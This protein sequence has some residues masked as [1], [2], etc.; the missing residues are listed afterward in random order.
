MAKQIS[1]GSLVTGL[2]LG[3]IIGIYINLLLPTSYYLFPN[4]NYVIIGLLALL[5]VYFDYSKPIFIEY[6]SY[7]VSMF[8]ILNFLWDIGVGSESKSGVMLVSLAVL[9]L[10]QNM[11]TGFIKILG[12]KTTARRAIGLQ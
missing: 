10:I 5:F 8:I 2:G 9:L 7:V 1:I 6:L 3:I 4:M 12:A 11:L